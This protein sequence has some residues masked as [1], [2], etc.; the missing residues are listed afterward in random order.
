[1]SESR[2]TVGFMN[3]QTKTGQ[4]VRFTSSPPDL[5]FEADSAIAGKRL[6]R[7]IVPAE[8]VAYIA[9]PDGNL[10]MLTQALR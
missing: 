6:A 4:L 3:G 7:E 5:L 2:V 9:D 8:R 1:M 10:L